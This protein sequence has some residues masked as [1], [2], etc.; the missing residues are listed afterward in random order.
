MRVAHNAL[1]AGAVM[2]AIAG[3]FAVAA[4]M[5]LP[6]P[7]FAGSENGNGNGNGNGNNGNG[8]IASEL[9]WRN[10]AHV[11]AN[12]MANASENSRPGIWHSYKG[13]FATYDL[14]VATTAEKQ[15]AV[16]DLTLLD[17]VQIAEMFVDDEAYDNA[18]LAAQG[19][20]TA[21]MGAETL[22]KSELDGAS[23]GLGLDEL[24]E[25]AMGK[26][27]AMLGL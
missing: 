10:S 15:K 16:D 13:V 9:K 24:S 11:S 21:T 1:K 25:D 23:D 6:D 12:G 19:E 5:T 26:L 4:T 14:A 7:A 22:A 18:L 17:D 8:K 2:L 3:G 27:M 20:L